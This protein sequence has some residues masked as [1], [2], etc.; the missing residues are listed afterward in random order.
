M[1]RIK[2]WACGLRTNAASS[3]SGNFRSATKRPAPVIS[4]RSSRRRTAAPI[5]V[6]CCAPW[7]ASVSFDISRARLLR[8][9]L[10]GAR[11]HRLRLEGAVAHLEIGLEPAGALSLEQ[12]LA[13]LVVGRVCE[14]A[15]RALEQQPGIK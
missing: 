15:E 3:M 4:G 6:V 5:C 8:P 1:P 10:G 12:L 13:E 14:R 11:T 2:A 9:S 7:P